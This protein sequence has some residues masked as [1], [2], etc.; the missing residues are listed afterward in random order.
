MDAA[1][2]WPLSSTAA[3]AR[4]GTPPNRDTTLT[5]QFKASPDRLLLSGGE[6]SGTDATGMRRARPARMTLARTGSNGLQ[7]DRRARLILGDHLP[8]W[9]A[10]NAA[11]RLTLPGLGGIQYGASSPSQIGEYDLW[12]VQ[13]IKS[14]QF[15]NISSLR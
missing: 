11:R 2:A 3:K 12:R 13:S 15:V 5:V 10:A 8:R 7:L 1:I 6:P 4:P 9:R 14:V